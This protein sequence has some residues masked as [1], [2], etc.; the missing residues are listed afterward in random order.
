MY[1]VHDLESLASLVLRSAIIL[2]FFLR[3]Q[4]LFQALPSLP[5]EME[6]LVFRTTEELKQNGAR[7]DYWSSSSLTVD[8]YRISACFS[9]LLLVL[10]NQ[11]VCFIFRLLTCWTS[12][13][14]SLFLMQFSF[15]ISSSPTQFL[16]M[17][18]CLKHFHKTQNTHCLK[19]TFFL[20]FVFYFVLSFLSVSVSGHSSEW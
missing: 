3:F 7:G 20:H 9:L 15:W 16:T 2:C 8:S 1:L 5:S 12:N 17:I 10:L 18:H 19:H 11:C 6:T 14:K 13:S 4:R